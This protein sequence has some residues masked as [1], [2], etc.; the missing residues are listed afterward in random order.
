[1]ELLFELLVGGREGHKGKGGGQSMRLCNPRLYMHTSCLMSPAR[2]GGAV[3]VC[4]TSQ[5]PPP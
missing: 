2:G 5:P 3:L 4:D 1:M